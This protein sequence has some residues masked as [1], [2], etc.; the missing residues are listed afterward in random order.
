MRCVVDCREDIELN[1]EMGESINKNVDYLRSMIK[2][3]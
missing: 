3:N 2:P 1:N